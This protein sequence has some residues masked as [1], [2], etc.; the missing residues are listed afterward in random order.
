[1]SLDFIGINLYSR[2]VVADNP[3][4]KNTSAQRIELP[5]VERTDFGPS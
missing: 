4:D 2:A 1:V 3:E 5:D